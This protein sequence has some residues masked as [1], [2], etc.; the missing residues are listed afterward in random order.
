MKLS[1]ASLIALSAFVVGLSVAASPAQAIPITYNFTG[2]V[3]QDFT[4]NPLAGPFSDGQSAFGTM[5]FDT[6][7]ADLNGAPDAGFYLALLSINITV[8]GYSASATGGSIDVF[9]DNPEDGLFFGAAVD[10]GLY[11][12][13]ATVTGAQVNGLDLGILALVLSE[14]SALGSDA[15]PSSLTLA[16]WA[17]AYGY[18]GFQDLSPPGMEEYS[19][20]FQIDTLT[21]VV[22]PEPN[23]VVLFGSALVGLVVARRRLKR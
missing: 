14:G 12:G 23:S 1:R 11:S 13:S 21:E 6:S 15:L 3:S 10:E 8:G 4:G 17:L 22:V 20:T 7:V 9:D 19:V 16:D 5:T 18:L 2:T